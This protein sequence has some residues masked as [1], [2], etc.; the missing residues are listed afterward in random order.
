[1]SLNTAQLVA[2]KD[3]ILVD[4][5][6]AAFPPGA[7]SSYSIADALNSLASP[8]FVVWRTKVTQDE[9]T[10]NG[11]T[12]TEVDNLSVGKARIWEWLFKNSEAAFNPSKANVRAGVVE[13]W[14]GTAGKL[15]V[16][17]AVFGHCKRSATRFEKIF[18]T[19]TG[20]DASPANLVLEGEVS[21]DDVQAARELP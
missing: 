4:P 16:Q 2:L 13:C 7:A 6:L 1:M 14:S 8:A 18:A 12:W 5:V 11:F 21:A 17:A 9:I 19:G 10:Q 3:A 15:A 20:S